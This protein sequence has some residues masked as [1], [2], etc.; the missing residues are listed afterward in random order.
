MRIL[1][2]SFKTSLSNNVVYKY[3]VA[4]KFG[5]HR[6]RLRVPASA[7]R[8]GRSEGPHLILPNFYPLEGLGVGSGIQNCAHLLKRL[9]DTCNNGTNT[10]SRVLDA[11]KS[12]LHLCI[13][14]NVGHTEHF[15]EEVTLSQNL[16]SV[17]RR[18]VHGVRLQTTSL[19]YCCQTLNVYH[20][21]Q[22]VSL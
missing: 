17:C 2:V 9:N 20:C 8:C 14:C 5:N 12:G 10:I 15:V 7:D 1:P 11:G 6:K 4:R 19:L 18:T 22:N 3:K 21:S 16:T 13:R